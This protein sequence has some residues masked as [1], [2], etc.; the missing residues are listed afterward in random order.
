MQSD[1]TF[2][3]DHSYSI[4]LDYNKLPSKQREM[5]NSKR[6][7]TSKKRSNV[8]TTPTNRTVSIDRS[9]SDKENNSTNVINTSG[10]KTKKK[11]TEKKQNNKTS[12]K[13][14]VKSTQGGSIIKKKKPIKMD[15]SD[16]SPS[17]SIEERVKLRRTTPF[18][19]AIKP[20]LNKKSPSNKN[21][22]I[23]KSVKR[24]H[25][26]KQQP[27]INVIKPKKFFLGSGLDLDNIVLGNRQRRSVQT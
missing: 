7:V 23:K 22:P 12:S 20:V 25:L 17:L 6:R 27:N 11:T 13:T 10:N 9:S 18:S 2:L 1:Y 26:S 5:K 4:R 24:I 16:A 3:T 8:Q 19:T 14:G 21:H 15:T